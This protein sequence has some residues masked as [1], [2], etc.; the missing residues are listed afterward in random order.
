MFE[1]LA[2]KVL[3]RL[4]SKYFISDDST[5]STSTSAPSA[6]SN[7]NQNSW[8]NLGVWSGYVSL[9]QLEFKKEL[10][11]EYFRAR[12]IPVDVLSCTIKRVEITVPW[13]KL[14]DP[15]EVV[16]VVLDG[17]HLLMRAHLHRHD[18]R[19]V[20]NHMIQQ[21]K[22]ALAESELFG[23][24]VAESSYTEMFKKKATEGII[25]DILDKLHIHI[26]NVHV[27]VEDVDT[28]SPFAIGLTLE[29]LHIHHDNSTASN[30]DDP[31]DDNFNY[32]K[33]VVRKVA[34]L[35]HLAIYWNAVADSRHTK[36][37][38]PVELSMLV[39]MEQSQ[40]IAKALDQ[41]IARRAS[42]L[43]SSS[44]SA[45]PKHV[46]L[47]LPVD[48]TAHVTLS[49]TPNDLSMRPA[50]V[51]TLQI[52]DVSVQIRD[53]QLSHIMAL[54]SSLQEHFFVQQYRPYFRPKLSALV[55]PKAW[56]EYAV[57]IIR[58]ELR[59]SR[60]RWSWSRFH[61]RYEQRRRYC[62]LFERQQRSRRQQV[63]ANGTNI[64]PHKV[65]ITAVQEDENENGTIF[66]V[67][68]EAIM[69][70][71]TEGDTVCDSPMRSSGTDSLNR[72]P[73]SPNE[74]NELAEIEDGLRGD[75]AV[76]DIVLF[77]ALIKA[78]LATIA[79][80]EHGRQKLKR[81]SRLRRLVS[82]VINDDIESEEE[83]E[84][85]LAY[86]E[87]A[88]KELDSQCEDLNLRSL[89]AISIQANLEHG[90]ISLFSPLPSTA[91]LNQHRRIHERFLDLSISHLY[92]GYSLLAN[93]EAFELQSSLDTLSVKEVR[94]DKREYTVISRLC[95]LAQAEAIQSPDNDKR[96]L[97][98]V[99]LISD[100][101]DH[102]EYD[103]GVHA[104]IDS[105]LISLSP[106]CEWI[107]H[108]RGLFN[109]SMSDTSKKMFW[110]G[111]RMA[112][113]SSSDSRR[114]EF[115]TMIDAAL[116]KHKNLDLDIQIKMPTI[117]INDSDD[118]FFSIYLG[119]ASIATD[120]L[121]GMS[122]G[123]LNFSSL[124]EIRRKSSLDQNG[125]RI[126]DE[127]GNRASTPVEDDRSGSLT[128][129]LSP[130]L[131]P[132]MDAL[133]LRGSSSPISR[134]LDAI[135]LGRSSSSVLDDKRQ[136]GRSRSLSITENMFVSTIDQTDDM[137]YESTVN[138]VQS[139][140]YDIFIVRLSK[141]RISMK[142]YGES[143]VSDFLTQFEI[144]I[145]FEISVLPSD[146]TLCRLI[147]NCVI[148]EIGVSCSASDVENM[149]F[150]F[151]SW[152]LA[153]SSFRQESL[154]TLSAENKVK[155]DIRTR[156]SPFLNST[157]TAETPENS[158]DSSS[159]LDE[160]EFIDAM[161]GGDSEG[162][163]DWFDENFVV[164]TESTVASESQSIP[165]SARR[166]RRPRSMSDT[167]SIS[168][169]SVVQPQRKMQR[170]DGAY[171]SAENLAKLDENGRE[172]HSDTESEGSYHSA[173]VSLQDHQE[174]LDAIKHD[175]DRVTDQIWKLN[176]KLV[177]CNIS[178]DAELDYVSTSTESSKRRLLRKSI[179]LDMSRA[180]AEL[181]ALHATRLDLLNSLPDYSDSVSRQD[182]TTMAPSVPFRQ[183]RKDRVIERANL[184]LRSRRKRVSIMES[185][186]LVHSLT[187]MLNR[188]I[189]RGSFQVKRFSFQLS[190]L[191]SILDQSVT[192]DTTMSKLSIATTH[193]SNDT[194][195][196]ASIDGIQVRSWIDSF[197]ERN[198]V[199]TGGD[200]YTLAHTMLPAE[201]P[202]LISSSTSDEK[203]MRF[204][205]HA[206]GK[207]SGGKISKVRLL[208]GGVEIVPR[209][210][211]TSALLILKSIVSGPREENTGI[212]LDSEL[213]GFC[214]KLLGKH[215]VGMQTHGM[216]FIMR[217]SSVRCRFVQGG[218]TIGAFSAS[219]VGVRVAR[220][221]KH[222]S[223]SSKCQVDLRCTN[224][225]V[226]E[227]KSTDSSHAVEILGR[228]DPFGHLL[229]TR[230]RMQTVSS[231]VVSG[232]VVG[233]REEDMMPVSKSC[234]NCHVGIRCNA[235]QVV[236]SLA[237]FAAM[238]DTLVDHSCMHEGA[239]P[240]RSNLARNAKEYTGAIPPFVSPSLRWRSDFSAASVAI[241][242]PGK[243]YNQLVFPG[244]IDGNVLLSLSVQACAQRDSTYSKGVDIH[245]TTDVSVTRTADD[246]P[247]IEKTTLHASLYVPNILRGDAIAP[248]Q[249][250]FPDDSSWV[251][252]KCS[253]LLNSAIVNDEARA[254]GVICFMPLRMNISSQICSLLILSYEGLKNN[255]GTGS[256]RNP[257]RTK[258]MISEFEGRIVFDLVEARLM[259]Q[260]QNNSNISLADRISSIQL[261]KCSF[262]ANVRDDEAIAH[263][264]VSQTTV[265]DLSSL[266]GVRIVGSSP[267]GD[268]GEI[269]FLRISI[270]VSNPVSGPAMLQVNVRWGDVQII[271][272]PSFI[273]SLLQF[274]TELDEFL[275]FNSISDTSKSRAGASFLSQDIFIVFSLEIRNFELVL[276]SRSILAYLRDKSK[277]P[278][279][280]V[281]FRWASSTKGFLLLKH[282]LPEVRPA[283]P[284]SS[285]VDIDDLLTKATNDFKTLGDFGER[286][287]NR[288][289]IPS[290]V[291]GSANAL[292]SSCEWQAF[293]IRVN[294]AVTGFQALRTTIQQ[295][296]EAFKNTE[297]G[298]PH[299][300][301]VQPPI[302]GEQR[303]TNQINFRTRYRLSGT[304]FGSQRTDATSAQ[305]HR[306][307]TSIAQA[308]HFDA[309]FVDVL[310]Y[311][312]QSAGGLN[313]AYRETIQPIQ[314]LLKTS[315]HDGVSVSS[316]RKES[317][318][319]D[320][321]RKATTVFSTKL[322]GFQVTCVPGGAT[323]LTESPIIK[324]ALSN[325]RLSLALLFVPRQVDEITNG[326]STFGIIRGS[327]DL[328]PGSFTASGC[329]SG[330]LSAHYH[331]RRLV[332]WE[333]VV[334]PWTVHVQFG[335]DLNRLFGQP[336]ARSIWRI[337][338]KPLTSTERLRDIGLRWVSKFSPDPKKPESQQQ[339]CKLNW[340]SYVRHAI[341]SSYFLRVGHYRKSPLRFFS[342]RS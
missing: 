163:N 173:V 43:A 115:L 78:R 162:N 127:N 130:R 255:R 21:R 219:E 58:M 1:R 248:Y 80:S 52:D 251:Q 223:L 282:A 76:Y 54:K 91:D 18:D 9:E 304:G 142:H 63:A 157:S 318:F 225:Q 145:I 75:L 171:L 327:E 32:S 133:N 217:F 293:T 161:D 44:Q 249:L 227:V 332:A 200:D 10:L 114:A 81:K 301:I 341:Y 212:D 155:D 320:L 144:K 180:E 299:K 25:K 236:A 47:L 159:V 50:V 195:V 109:I 102:P 8:T 87:N 185:D 252:E 82:S 176:R 65:L 28:P 170:N 118:R 148:E 206:K 184:V 61:Q 7:I 125:H 106:S 37:M 151:R 92:V 19:A 230:I 182:S 303:I 68:H 201:F 141:P 265:C 84:H 326:S 216:D 23:K 108:V 323:R 166:L 330:E 220:S 169:L 22:Q 272:I 229:F 2:G 13:A 290:L 240:M 107:H 121:A 284:A 312:R 113:S 27:R 29:S 264:D 100:P 234:I 30:T 167:S 253:T 198:V 112:Q 128:E 67:T 140:F 111:L 257:R 277:N 308:V 36:G 131:V 204:A 11:N 333:P 70:D 101:P 66:N 232:W 329:T 181:K 69:P 279:N 86:L 4:L 172:D 197:A 120:R 85:L 275:G 254:Q 271:P 317:A 153:L 136:F 311:I 60:M 20:R 336:I 208:I 287:L 45:S 189:F 235:L 260:S 53:F 6:G 190:R 158:S 322:E 285:L 244:S 288:F 79:A 150:I 77:R 5:S 316:E 207:N 99:Q 340:E 96:H 222:V 292:Y 42:P 71:T 122:T 291:L 205:L 39:W 339:K 215:P 210:E 98:F 314:A 268:E 239:T 258:P 199:F 324:A 31:E 38:I 154:S 177:E 262:L 298:T 156:L 273:K 94:S 309:G 269:D 175:I 194:K 164:D 196:F 325:L 12:G 168:E 305:S 16:V 286:C 138:S 237:A 123:K 14:H 274:K 233:G 191:S 335:A 276:S 126:R 179:K 83:Y 295:A 186:G 297:R 187:N 119:D 296:Q 218:H 241:V 33:T 62:E 137:T 40:Q 73:L 149:L 17:V 35:N 211:V 337:E 104:Q 302:Y 263:F 46:Y 26:R 110:E 124:H 51:L 89:V 203:F 270:G 105:L 15:N 231:E 41:C 281:S 57:H 3:S 143:E 321:L 165:L 146:H 74:I 183:Q 243:S 342:S 221:M 300:L 193:Q 313:D 331:N 129:P 117:A 116:K 132:R 334:E 226:L 139:P 55:D 103:I 283:I 338:K 174:L 307:L 261:K 289:T 160:A 238:K 95:D 135:V 178:P 88:N 259:K 49:R 93:F 214:L 202:Q 134:G 247:I 228:R 280:V 294:L 97:V 152:Q 306:S 266:P 267:L 315:K 213:Q 192:L 48:A 64:S 147:A 278:I 34:Q 319:A 245:F 256:S 224:M 188:E 250:M 310:V 24:E 209:A 242:V 56:W 246:W 59:K 90:C 328:A 72:M